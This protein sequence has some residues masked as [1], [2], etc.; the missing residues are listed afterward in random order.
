MLWLPQFFVVA[1][2]TAK[3]YSGGSRIYK[4]QG[5]GAVGV[6]GDVGAEGSG[7]GIAPFSEIFFRFWI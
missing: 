7:E 1:Q 3:Y 4:G 5:Q 6:I 2:E